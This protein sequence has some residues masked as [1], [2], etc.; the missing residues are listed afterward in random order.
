MA[1]GALKG[2]TMGVSED[3]VVVLKVEDDEVD[4]QSTGSLPWNL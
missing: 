2:G 4:V 1:G 3:M